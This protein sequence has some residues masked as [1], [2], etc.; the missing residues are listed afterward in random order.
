MD[1][2]VGAGTSPTPENI[3]QYLT[4][5]NQM[6]DLTAALILAKKGGK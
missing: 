2:A 1:I 4:A 6:I 5:K 3:Q